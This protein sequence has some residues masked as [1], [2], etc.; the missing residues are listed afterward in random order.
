[1]WQKS[2]LSLPIDTDD[3]FLLSRG[4]HA[5][6]HL[7][8]VES[9]DR[10]DIGVEV[11]VGYHDV[12]DIF[13]RSSLCTLRRGVDGH[14]VGIF[15]PRFDPRH[16]HKRDRI[17]F[18]IT[19][20]LP[21]G[22][23]APTL[24]NFETRLPFFSQFFAR[25]PTYTFG[26]VMLHSTNSPIIAD[27]LVGDKIRIH[28]RNGPIEGTFNTSSSLDVE[29]SNSPV[30]VVVNAFNQNNSA[31]TSV[32]IRT[33]NGFLSADLSLVSTFENGTSGAFSVVAHTSNSPLDVNFSAHAP[34]GLLKLD[35]HTS[36]SPAQVQLHP[37]FEGT[38]KLR[39]SLF[40]ASVSPEPEV[41]DPAGRG[42]TRSVNV[43]PIG[44][45]SRIV[46]ADVAWLPEDEAL[47]PDGEV[48]VSTRNS[49]LVVR[50]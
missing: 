12:G 18:N 2:E 31:P 6:G 3:I 43:S 48:K 32:K 21:E 8:I 17:F 36:N 24:P 47:K 44:R 42:R 9:P 7:Q 38:L 5:F 19:L 50:L 30:K 45:H 20:S 34:D 23:D 41:D 40:V 10:E 1:V 13:E 35:A 11:I 46:H 49:P 14:G 4:F 39:T 29:T 22:K 26:T 27:N 28:S 33:R 25:L 15:T 37:S 16:H